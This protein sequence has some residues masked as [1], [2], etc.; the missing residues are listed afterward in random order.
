MH[1]QQTDRRGRA[2]G[3]AAVFIPRHFRG[4]TEENQ[5]LHPYY[6]VSAVADAFVRSGVPTADRRPPTA[7]RA[8]WHTPTARARLNPETEPMCCE[9][10]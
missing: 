6:S 1:R 3:S 2:P 9:R 7:D 5:E 4:Q 10:Q 8:E